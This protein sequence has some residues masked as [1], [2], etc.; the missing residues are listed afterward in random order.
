MSLAETVQP[1]TWPIATD[2][3]AHQLEAFDFAADR[4]AAMLAIGMGGGK[5]ALAIALAE[6]HAA[7]R[8]LVLCPK[9]VV[10]VWPAQF[11]QH[12]TRTW[13]AW[14]GHVTGA[15]GPLRNPSVARRA[16][17]L[18]D[19][20]ARGDID[21][22]PMVAVINYEAAPQ[23]DMGRLLLK[24]PWDIV[25]LDESH[26]I[27]APGGVQSRFAARVCQ[28]ARQ[29]GGRVLALTG[30]PMPHS[31]LDIYA[32]YRAID[33]TV[34]G[35]SNAA[36]RARY[37][38]PKV[39]YVTGDGHPVY[40]TTPG[41][42]PIY[43]GVRPDRMYELSERVGRIMFRV[44]QAQLDTQLGLAE[45]ADVYRTCE[46]AP[47]A[48]RV[49]DELERDGIAQVQD[50]VV[51]AANAMVVVL[52]LAQATSG[53]ARDAD[54]HAE[55]PLQDG[56]PDK[57][58]L[59]ADV[60]E[61]LPRT[62]AVVVFARF[63]HDLDAIRA[64]CEAQGRRY[65]ELS[66]RRRDGLTEHSTMAPNIDVLGAQLKSGGVG[67]DLTRARYGIY[68]SLDFALA[69]YAQSRKRLHRPGQ[70]RRVTYIHLLAESTVDRAI[71]GAL[72]RR[73]NVITA[74]LDHLNTK[75]K[76]P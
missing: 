43:E 14:A 70:Q 24:T 45:P 53:F 59:L 19:E 55:R 60:L 75:G 49:Y 30:T 35:T 17:A 58:R 69:D 64:V 47:N 5:S 62:E 40:L 7:Q 52:R 16:A 21:P 74:F 32:Q 20:I 18:T 68:F 72:R 44:D 39:K 57:A 22:R 37:G 51:T 13:R 25:I 34:L 76:T 26:R 4:R 63:H 11:S 50:G 1:A 29:N 73:E 6:H 61:D 48:R 12:A 2:P 56:A 9:S 38:A 33:P 65:G 71:Y 3:W 15:R 41:G 8:V 28:Q 46:L 54:S 23:G 36:F 66:G 42:H 27:K 31:P 67:I 10:G